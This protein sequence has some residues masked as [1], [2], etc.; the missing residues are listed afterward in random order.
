MFRSLILA[1]VVLIAPTVLRVLEP[2]RVSPNEMYQS[3]YCAELVRSGFTSTDYKTDELIKLIAAALIMGGDYLDYVDLGV[4][5]ARRTLL[6]QSQ[7]GALTG[8]LPSPSLRD[9][10]WTNQSISEEL[11]KCGRQLTEI[12]VSYDWFVCGFG[13]E[14]D[15]PLIYPT[16]TELDLLLEST[17]VEMVPSFAKYIGALELGKEYSLLLG[18][19]I[20]IDELKERATAFREAEK[21]KNETWFAKLAGWLQ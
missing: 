18:P 2:V 9:G 1:I 10:G 14:P 13:R 17:M 15:H 21:A 8:R 11:T 5:D 4:T 20:S 3:G 16:L 7:Q 19:P 6:A 12:I